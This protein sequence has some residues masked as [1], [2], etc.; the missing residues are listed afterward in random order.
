MQHHRAER[1]IDDPHPRVETVRGHHA[2]RERPPLPAPALEWWSENFALVRDIAV[3]RYPKRA[4]VAE[5]AVAIAAAAAS[6]CAF[7]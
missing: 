2:V 1:Q 7:W 5:V 6:A 3:R 4:G